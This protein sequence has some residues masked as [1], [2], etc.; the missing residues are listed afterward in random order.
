MGKN[1]G[2]EVVQVSERKCNYNW[3]RSSTPHEQLTTSWV[4]DFCNE[5]LWREIS[6]DCPSKH[7]S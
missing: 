7:L 1:E 6:Y 4:F 5:R 2:I 3:I